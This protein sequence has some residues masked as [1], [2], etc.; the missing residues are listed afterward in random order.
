[1]YVVLAVLLKKKL[2]TKVFNLSVQPHSWRGRRP[3]APC[4]ELPVGSHRQPVHVGRTGTPTRC[5][6]WWARTQTQAPR[7]ELGVPFRFV[8]LSVD[9]QKS[10]KNSTIFHTS[11]AQLLKPT[12]G[13]TTVQPANPEANGLRDRWLSPDLAQAC[14]GFPRAELLDAAPGPMLLCSPRLLSPLRSVQVPGLSTSLALLTRAD[15][16][17]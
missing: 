17:C 10:C 1:M 14:P 11:F 15:Q 16:F 2:K 4:R 6:K 5:G 12:S 8:E 7:P 13:V 9:L 3:A